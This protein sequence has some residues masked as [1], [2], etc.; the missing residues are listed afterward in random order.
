MGSTVRRERYF[1]NSQKTYD[2]IETPLRNPD[3]T[4]SKLSLS[5]DLTPIKQA[6]KALEEREMLYRSITESAADGAVM[7]Q[8]GK[9][10]F[11][12]HALVNMVVMITLQRIVWE[13][14][15]QPKV[16][17]PQANFHYE[18]LQQLEKEIWAIADTEYTR[19][20][21]NIL[22]QLILAWR[23]E[24]PDQQMVFSIRFTNFD[25]LKEIFQLAES[26]GLFS[27]LSKA[28]DAAEELRLLG[29]RIRFQ[30]SRMPL[31]LN[32]ELEM[33]Y[34]QLASKSEVQTLLQDS[35]RMATAVQQLAHVSAGLP[36][37]TQ[38]AFAKLETES[39]RLRSLLE[40]LNQT[41]GT[42]D[43][44]VTEINRAI[45]AVDS[46][47]SRF[48][49]MRTKGG[50]KP[51]KIDQLRGLAQDVTVT[52]RQLNDLLQTTNQFLSDPDKEKRL[53]NLVD[54]L[55]QVESQGERLI[56]LIFY[57]SL[58]IAFSILFGAFLLAVAYSRI[59]GKRGRISD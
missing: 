39:A 25:S 47:V 11:V 29:D 9:I 32:Y 4:V 44:L 38:N 8:D 55:A 21:L 33:A 13:E 35:T 41:M 37:M 57:R 7:V 46:I 56:N 24:N 26:K 14:H 34:M 17:S 6:Q 30:F 59:T 2:V 45:A 49:P 23:K 50:G 5:R 18:T 31:L 40:A 16:F 12:N 36:E 19:E 27:G 58:I 52:G 43:E 15:W 1:P 48:D 42:G 22:R 10:L 20:Q 53:A 28:V 3:G 54:A 51:I